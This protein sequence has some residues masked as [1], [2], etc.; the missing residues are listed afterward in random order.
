MNLASIEKLKF[1]LLT[2]LSGRKRPMTGQIAHTFAFNSRNIPCPG[3]T[4]QNQV[5]LEK[6]Q[7]PLRRGFSLVSTMSAS[8][9]G[10]NGSMQHL[11]SLGDAIARA[12]L[13]SITRVEFRFLAF[14]TR[15]FT[16]SD[17]D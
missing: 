7:T 12:Y 15:A 17:H 3:Q 8:G 16:T 4:Y 6:I 14:F 11:P 5:A 13:I 2:N 9:C 10:L 1:L